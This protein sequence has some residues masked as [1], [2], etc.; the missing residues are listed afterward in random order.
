MH[1][2][3]KGEEGK[4]QHRKEEEK[5][6]RVKAMNRGKVLKSLIQANEFKRSSSEK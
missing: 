1:K 4:D 6:K 2:E 5:E 3:A